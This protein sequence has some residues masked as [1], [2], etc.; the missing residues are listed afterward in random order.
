MVKIINCDIF[1]APIDVLI[2]GCNCFNTM[3]GGIAFFIKNLFPEAYEADLRT[4]KGDR[5]K[6]G[7]FSFATIDRK[8]TN[9]KYIFNLYQ[10]YEFG[11]YRPLNYEAFYNGLE[12]IRG[13]I[14][15]T[16]LV[17]GIP[18]GI[19]CGLAK[20]AWLIVYEMIKEVFKD[21]T[22]E[23]LICKKD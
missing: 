16:N 21:S 7:T 3:G 20:G 4:K 1:K 12:L 17:I 13:S 14:T 10:Q 19:G 2:H 22:L 18:Y 6:L 23:V 9:I 5:K 15:N 11:G 8:D